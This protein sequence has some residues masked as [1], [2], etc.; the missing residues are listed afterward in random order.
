MSKIESGPS[1]KRAQ[2]DFEDQG[3][4]K[5]SEDV[6]PDPQDFDKVDKEL[7]TDRID[8]TFDRALGS[9]PL[10]PKRDSKD[11]LPHPARKHTI[12]TW[13]KGVY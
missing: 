13:A 2:S 7:P 9:S 3:K 12:S 1:R 5:I 11:V 8:R 10:P 6:F 4:P